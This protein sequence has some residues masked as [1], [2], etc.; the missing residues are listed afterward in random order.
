MTTFSIVNE[1]TEVFS[2]EGYWES[3]LVYQAATMLQ[4]QQAEIEALKAKSEQAYEEGFKRGVQ[5]SA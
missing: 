1:L 2:Y 3:D 5:Q 4:K